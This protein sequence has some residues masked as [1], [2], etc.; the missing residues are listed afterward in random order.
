MHADHI[1]GLPSIILHTTTPLQ[2]QGERTPP[3]HIYGPFGLYEYLCTS[4]RLSQS[5]TKRE[6]VVHEMIISDAD[7]RDMLDHRGER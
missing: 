7:A 5:T 3:L 4:L 2:F 6:V 1:F